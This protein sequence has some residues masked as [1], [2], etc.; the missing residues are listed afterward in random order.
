M[1]IASIVMLALT[2]CEKAEQPNL[3]TTKTYSF[4]D[5]SS[6]YK[7]L[8]DGVEDLGYIVGNVASGQTVIVEMIYTIQEY[9]GT[10]RIAQHTVTMP[11][12]SGLQK[13]VADDLAEYVTVQV[14]M[15]VQMEKQDN[16]KTLFVGNAFYL[17]AGKN[18]AIEITDDTMYSQTNPI[19]K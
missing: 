4:I 1:I 7:A 13:F 16:R 14:T 15:H 19:A 5:K 2:S 3:P 12:D 18:V 6:S 17:T 8:R 10:Q 9:K 11:K